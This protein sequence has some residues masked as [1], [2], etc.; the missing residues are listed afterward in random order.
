MPNFIDY[1]DIGPAAAR[2]QWQ[3]VL[4]RTPVT[5]GRQVNFLPVETLTCLAASFLVNH[6]KY[7]GSTAHLAEEP[8]PTLG[9]L[10]QRPNSSV[11][12][13]MANLDGSR[14]NG[15]KHEIEV[16]A[17]LLAVPGRLGVIYRVIL[18]AARDL[19]IGSKNL[20]D[21]LSLADD[22]GELRL[23]G[24]DRLETA[25]VESAVQATSIEWL[26]SRADLDE[27]TTERLL[28]AAVRVGQH[29]FANE[30]LRNHH[31]RCVFCGLSVKIAGDRAAR[32]L[33]ASHIKPWRVSTPAERLDARNGLTACPTHDVA[34]DT[35]LMTVNGGLRIHLK[36][37]LAD[38]V[39]KDA[40]ARAAFG[41]PP[42]ADSLLLP[43]TAPS[44]R[45]RYLNW[46]HH[47]VYG[48]TPSMAP[49]ELRPRARPEPAGSP[50]PVSARD[51]ANHSR[52]ARDQ[53]DGA[54][55]SE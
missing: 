1:V 19:G 14:R 12:A 26:K 39:L 55:R 6:R 29:R 10:F 52:R 40:A 45:A 30:V 21:F 27:Q 49:S 25:A 31:H 8:V 44:P 7:G 35:G 38:A 15:A 28:V 18:A 4:A 23:S 24:Q 32:M 5:A 37:S 50:S 53:D 34:F 41:R 54:D 17:H 11:L 20:P 3:A 48:G 13:K 47:H 22:G 2:S 43:A 51:L 46:H 16:A 36:P 33:V 42:L 9:R